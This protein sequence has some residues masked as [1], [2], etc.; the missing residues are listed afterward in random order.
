MELE[1]CL[2]KPSWC[3]R[4]LWELKFEVNKFTSTWQAPLWNRTILSVDAIN[5][6]FS[7]FLGN[8]NLVEQLHQ[9]TSPL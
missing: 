8:F 5:V 4:S 2:L 9:I 7:G 1:C 6:A 3:A